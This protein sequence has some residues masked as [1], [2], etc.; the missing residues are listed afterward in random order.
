LLRDFFKLNDE[1]SA[2]RVADAA[3][4]EGMFANTS[5]L[6]DAAVCSIDFPPRTTIFRN[7]KF[8]NVNFGKST[9]GEITFTNCQFED[10]LFVSCKFD[11]VEFHGCRFI[12]C[13]FYKVS[14]NKT[15]LDCRVIRFDRQ[16][17]K[18]CSNI[19]LGFYQDL[20]ANY[21]NDHQWKFSIYADMRR[22][23]WD[24]YQTWYRIRRWKPARGRE[25]LG[26][27]WEFIVL[28]GGYLGSLGYAA[29]IRYGYGPFRFLA[30]SL[31]GILLLAA[32][33]QAYWVE[34]GLGQA[35]PSISQALFFV[36]TLA[37]TIGYAS[38]IPTTDLGFAFSAGLGLLGVAWT[39]VFIAI[40]LR[41]FVR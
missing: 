39:G 12:N 35:Q 6:I 13:N 31:V 26:S 1:N 22:R 34:L 17:R 32:Y 5:E 14:F 7:K 19:M 8:R 3:A 24:R 10:C 29:L 37:S 21:Q 30:F 16:L 25:F 38:H 23:E 33:A 40:L 4:F 11:D 9:F 15:Y 36:S 20:Y 18:S 41:R 28:I 2:L 27:V